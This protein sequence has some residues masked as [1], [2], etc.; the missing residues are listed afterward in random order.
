MAAETALPRI[1]KSREGSYYPNMPPLIACH[2]NSYGRHGAV[3]AIEH[4]RDAGIEWIELPIRTA[5]FRTRWGDAA[6]VSTDSTF[7]DLSHVDALLERHGVHVVSCT[8]LAGNPLDPANTELVRRKLDLASHFGVAV[9]I[10]DAGW[11]DDE[12]GR[13]QIYARLREIGDYAD[14]RGI[15][16]CCETQRGLCLNHREMLTT[17][18]EVNHPRIRANFDTGN[19]LYYNERIQAE[20]ALAKVCH[21]V[22]HVRLKESLGV[23]GEW[24]ATAL[25][26]GGAVDFLRTY[27][28]MRDCGFRAPFSIAIEG[29]EGEP[30]LSLAEH[31]QRVVESVKYLRG[32][33]YFD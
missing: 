27:Q 18:N 13:E 14:K 19:L 17:L 9:A 5:G 15:T 26:N 25:G 31:H 30:D 6:L 16:A 32:I 3:A 2:T 20:V 1:V 21:L 7:A 29:V 11:A 8:C 33:G 12:T 4:I 22:G 24:H 10:I 28:I 23:P